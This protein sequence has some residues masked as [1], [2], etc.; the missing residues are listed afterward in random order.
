MGRKKRLRDMTWD[1]YGISRNRRKELEAFCLQYEEKRRKI[2]SGISSVQVDG[3]PGSNYKEGPVEKQ[4]IQNSTYLH[5]V[6][7]IEEAAIRANPGIWKYLLKSA[8]RGLPYERIE[9]ADELGRIP[10]GSTEFYAYRRLFYRYLD[11][12]KIGYKSKA[13][14]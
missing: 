1:D 5:D 10:V 2:Q 13:I 9:Y 7:M 8:T 4:A 6:R 14:P 11:E 3:I 12:L